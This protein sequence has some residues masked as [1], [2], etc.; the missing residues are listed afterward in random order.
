VRGLSRFDATQSRN[1][2]DSH[3]CHRSPRRQGS[4]AVPVST[5]A[6]VTTLSARIEIDGDRLVVDGLLCP[7]LDAEFDRV[8]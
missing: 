7:R 3:R 6:D 2:Y 5:R 1:F 8:G 4:S